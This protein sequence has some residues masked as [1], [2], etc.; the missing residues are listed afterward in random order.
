MTIIKK[1]SANQKRKTFTIWT[2]SGNKYRTDSMDKKTFEECE[3]NTLGDWS[4]F[5]RRGF[6]LSLIK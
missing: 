1:V 3:Y 5:V 6:D 2:A 4:H